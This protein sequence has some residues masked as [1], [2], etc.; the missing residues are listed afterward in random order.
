MPLA[1]VFTHHKILSL[2]LRLDVDCTTVD[3][4]E[5]ECGVTL[6]ARGDKFLEELFHRKKKGKRLILSCNR[7]RTLVQ[8]HHAAEGKQRGKALVIAGQVNSLKMMVR[9]L[10]I[11]H[12]V[13]NSQGFPQM[14]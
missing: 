11:A 9:Y 14:F 7:G 3:F 2:P 12:L 1:G 4:G 6:N 13:Q 5:E 8:Q 10:A